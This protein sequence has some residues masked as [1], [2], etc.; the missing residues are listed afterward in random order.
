MDDLDKA[1]ASPG[2]LA[3]EGYDK[4]GAGED[5]CLFGGRSSSASTSLGESLNWEK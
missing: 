1:A 5:I 3:I 2:E 4:Y